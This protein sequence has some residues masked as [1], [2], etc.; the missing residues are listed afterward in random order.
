[1]IKF[2]KIIVSVDGSETKVYD[3][4]AIIEG[5]SNGAHMLTI[6]LLNG[7]TPVKSK[8]INIT[9]VAGEIQNNPIYQDVLDLASDS[10][11][12]H[13][14]ATQKAIDNQIANDYESAG[15]WTKNDA[16]M[17][18]KGSAPVPFKLLDWK[19]LI[20]VDAYGGLTWSADGV[21]GDAASG[22]IDPKF[23]VTSRNNFTANN[24]HIGIGYFDIYSNS[25]LYCDVGIYEGG[26]H[27]IYFIPHRGSNS[28]AALNSNYKLDLPPVTTVGFSALNKSSAD[29]IKLCTPGGI[30]TR[31]GFTSDGAMHPETPYILARQAYQYGGLTTSGYSG[32]GISYITFGAD[33]SAEYEN[34]KSILG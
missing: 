29:T 31:T 6:T 26:N 22:Y 24:S 19:R 33:L 11:I 25:S 20:K 3:F 2:N 34:V 18:F 1:M 23:D 17:K 8:T 12:E 32:S 13:P 5:L 16:F 21:K 9:K 14:D 30:T 10:A 28:F 15:A 4:N 27:D 7:S